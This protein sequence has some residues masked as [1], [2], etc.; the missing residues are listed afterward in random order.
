MILR[1]ANQTAITA[2]QNEARHLIRELEPTILQVNTANV[3]GTNPT[4]DIKLQTSADGTNWIDVS[5][6]APQLTAAG[7]S[8][9]VFSAGAKLSNF[10]RA[11]ATIGGTDTPTFD[12]EIL[13][14]AIDYDK[15]GS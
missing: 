1:L 2:T 7:S 4:L 10:V 9:T 6:T 14:G 13:L 12:Y 3:T 5:M 11:V 8:A 15:E